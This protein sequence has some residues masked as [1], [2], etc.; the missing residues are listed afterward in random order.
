MSRRYLYAVILS[1]VI[2][3][4]S[5]ANPLLVFAEGFGPFPVRNFQPLHQLVLGMPGDRATVL[6][7][8]ALDLRVELANTANIFSDTTPQTS[9]TVKFESVRSGFFLR[10]GLTERLEMAVEVPVLYRYHG[11]MEGMISAVER[12]TTGWAPDR[13]A[14]KGTNYAYHVT[15][16]G[17]TV[18]NARDG[19]VGLGDASVMGKYQVLTE[20]DILPALSIRAA[21]KLP[22]GEEP[23][24]LGSGSPDYGFGLALEKHV[25]KDWI[26]YANLNGVVPTGRIAGYGLQSVVSGLIAV[27]YLWSENFSLVGHF[28][29]YSSPFHGTGTAVFDKGVTEGVLGVN[30]RLRPQLLW[31]VYAVE[32]LD[33]IVGS[34]ADFT[35]ST[36][37]TFQF[38]S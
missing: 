23:Q 25:A 21:V 20:T 11:I 19:V 22:T 17:R 34:A 15:S 24:L 35:L 38:G 16:D 27:E 1:L 7:P 13:R 5:G 8:G 6:K 37:V 14:L 29:Y 28:D 32:N 33:F 9:V 12:A 18:I 10:Y 26:V 4:M 2:A 30:Y 31:Q 3:A 36:V